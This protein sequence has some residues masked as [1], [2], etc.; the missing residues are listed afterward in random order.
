MT[1]YALKFVSAVIVLLIKLTRLNDS[2]VNALVEEFIK[3]I[4]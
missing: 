4:G 3:K 1:A 2:R